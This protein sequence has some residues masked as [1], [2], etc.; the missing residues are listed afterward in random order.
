MS[1]APP[2]NGE[3]LD[4]KLW[5]RRKGSKVT[6]GLTSLAVEDVGSAESVEF[7][8]EGSDFEKGEAIVTVIGS[9]GRIEVPAPAS[10]VVSEWNEAASSEPEMITDDP[11]E[12]GWLIQIEIEDPSDLREYAAEADESEE[13]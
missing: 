8:S 11:F 5:F 2:K 3:Y 1:D 13:D 4:G 10:G 6:V 12:E 9:N 7:P